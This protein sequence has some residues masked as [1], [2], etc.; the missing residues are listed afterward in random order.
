MLSNEIIH[1]ISEIADVIQNGTAT[2]VEKDELITLIYSN[3]S[4]TPELYDKYLNGVY[5]LEEFT[6]LAMNIGA[7]ILLGYVLHRVTELI[8]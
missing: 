3:G 8:P 6:S 2:P 4:I 5:T 1:R 7:I